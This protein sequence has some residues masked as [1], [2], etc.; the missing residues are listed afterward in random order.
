[1]VRVQL[2]DTA[3]KKLTTFTERVEIVDSTGRVV[4]WYE[5]GAVK[6]IEGC[7]LT[8]AEIADAI[9]QE[10]GRSLSEIMTDLR[11]S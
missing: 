2:E 1:M 5:P 6:P 8:S 9:S 3:I 10:G 4:G 11:S 7:P